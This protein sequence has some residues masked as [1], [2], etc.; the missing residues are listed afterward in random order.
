MLR[1]PEISIL[2]LIDLVECR[3]SKQEYKKVLENEETH[4]DVDLLYG[5]KDN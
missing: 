1:N 5:E 3:Y 4:K 2:L